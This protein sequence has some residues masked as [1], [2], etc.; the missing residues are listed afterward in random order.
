M[1]NSYRLTLLNF[2]ILLTVVLAAGVATADIF[3]YTAILT[4]NN[5]VPSV[6]TAATGI[7]TLTLDNENGLLSA[8]P[9]HI[10][11]SGLSSTQ[12]AAHIHKAGAGFNGAAI[13]TV[14]LG[15]IVDTT[16]AFD[17]VALASL[18]AEGLYLNIH[19]VNFPGGEI[20]G[21]FLLSN[22]VDAENTTWGNIKSL[23]R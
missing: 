7:A 19:S 22:T 9:L 12:T 15:D 23:Y 5:E 16:V 20:R 10:E 14:P 11:F 1:N 13:I 2:C 3:T 6:V 4:G 8:I 17:L 18:P 21:Q